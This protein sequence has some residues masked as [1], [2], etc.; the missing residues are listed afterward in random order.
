MTQ[1]PSGATSVGGNV[2]ELLDSP[3]G[4]GEIKPFPENDRVL[5][6]FK[7]PP[8]RACQR[9]LCHCLKRVSREVEAPQGGTGESL[10]GLGLT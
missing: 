9:L 10:Q 8:G 7:I 5:I 6:V 4:I 3:G 1:S 2:I